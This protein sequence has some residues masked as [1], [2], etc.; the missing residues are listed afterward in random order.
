M[1]KSALDQQ[2]KNLTQRCRLRGTR[3]QANYRNHYRWCMGGSRRAAERETE[4]RRGQLRDCGDNRRVRR[5]TQCD[6]YASTAMD[7][8]EQANANNCRTSN[9]EWDKEHERVYEWC[10]DNGRS[11]RRDVLERAQTK[12]AAC[13]RRGGGE[14]AL[15]VA[16]PMQKMRLRKLIRPKRTLA[17]LAGRHGLGI[18]KPITRHVAI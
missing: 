14:N 10:R 7:V 15:N 18:L 4:A 1:P 17:G 16:K 11:K 5:D 6:R 3:W 9:R 2:D 12:L 8:L 13:I